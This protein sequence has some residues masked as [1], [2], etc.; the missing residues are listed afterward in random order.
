MGLI[1]RAM[2]KL[3]D[4]LPMWAKFILGTLVVVGIVYGIAHEG[5]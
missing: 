2:D 4:K 1:S 5:F 3:L